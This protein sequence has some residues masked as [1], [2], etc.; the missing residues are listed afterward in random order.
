[1]RTYRVTFKVDI[2]GASGEVTAASLCSAV[3]GDLLKEHSL[4]PEC[5]FDLSDVAV[6]Q[7]S[8]EV[9]ET[10]MSIERSHV[11]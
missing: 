8:C 5:P 7:F 2:R 4:M 11:D 10:G 9:E 1:M 3:M 6:D